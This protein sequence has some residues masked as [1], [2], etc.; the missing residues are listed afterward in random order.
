MGFVARDCIQECRE[1]CGGHGYLTLSGLG[2]IHDDHEPNLTYEGDN[3]VILQQTANYL[4]GMMR[5]GKG[6]AKS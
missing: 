1:A 2:V 5:E 3:N 4:F 6:N